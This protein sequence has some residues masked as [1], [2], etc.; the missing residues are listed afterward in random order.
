MGRIKRTVEALQDTLQQPVETVTRQAR[1]DIGGSGVDDIDPPSDMDQFYDQYKSTGF[2]RS[3]FDQ[4]V[5]DVTEPGVRIEADSDQT[6]AYFMGGDGAPSDTPE[7]GFLENCFVLA[8][9]KGQD[10]HPG[11]KT[12]VLNRWVRGT[13]TIELLKANDDD[14]E[15][16]ITGFY[17]I[18][19]ETLTAQV[20]PN[21]NI[22][23]DPEDTD[24]AEEMGIELTKR[25]EAAAYIQFDEQ[26]IIGR[27]LGIF[28]QRESIPLSQNDVLKQTL[29]PE[30]GGE[31]TNEEGI[32]GTS[33][34]E[35]I[36][37]DIEEY[38]EIKRDRARAIKTKAYGL[39]DAS[40]QKEI[41][42]LGGEIEVTEWDNESIDD[43]LDKVDEIGPGDIVG[44]DGAIELDKFDSEVPD[45][46][47]VLGHYVDD[48]TSPLP[49]PKYAIGFEKNINQF[50]TERQESRYEQLVSEER[51]YQ[52]R[53]WLDAFK[54]VAERKG[55]DTSGMRV[56]IEP[57]EDESPVRS[58]SDED[59]A[60]IR[61]YTQSLADVYGNG[62]APSFVDEETL[63]EL[64]LQ[65]PEDSEPPEP[66]EGPDDVVPPPEPPGSD[67]EDMPPEPDGQQQEANAA[68]DAMMSMDIEDESDESQVQFST[69]ANELRAYGSD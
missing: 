59:V 7:G 58:L 53:S 13:N 28:D 50:V 3:N 29:S 62:G 44:H 54:M 2:V 67:G 24:G 61:E 51:R 10:F 15:S 16:E 23:I 37:I 36:S 9:E 55:L 25:G 1:L 63:R 38:K 22:L 42:D 60:R 19:P 5:S 46:E 4:F 56:R 27:R 14:P 26:S 69:L 18:R 32:F 35:A 8:G 20:Y 34:F 6:Q 30:I 17:H 43:W 12:T 64:I 39:W 21:T 45:L 11:L 33:I 41:H 57:E 47:G 68:F 52:E 40:F 48:I 66:E 31:D 65:L 49:A